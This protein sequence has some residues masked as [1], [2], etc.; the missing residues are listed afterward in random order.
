MDNLDIVEYPLN[1]YI[2]LSSRGFLTS[3]KYHCNTSNNDIYF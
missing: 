3:N 1:V 2:V